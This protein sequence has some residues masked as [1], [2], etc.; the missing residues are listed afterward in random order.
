MNKDIMKNKNNIEKIKSLRLYKILMVWLHFLHIN[1]RWNRNKKIKV[2][3]NFKLIQIDSYS[4]LF[5]S[6]LYIYFVCKP[7]AWNLV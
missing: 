2:L 5:L 4:T 6:I 3:K 1:K 7:F